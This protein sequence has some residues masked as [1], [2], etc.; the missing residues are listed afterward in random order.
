VK[1]QIELEGSTYDVN[2]EVVQELPV[3]VIDD[4]VTT[5]HGEYPTEP[6]T[7]IVNPPKKRKPR[8]RSASNELRSP[9]CGVIVSV[10][11]QPGDVVEADDVVVVL[12]AMKMETN[13]RAPRTCRVKSVSVQAGEAVLTDQLLVEFE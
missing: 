13:L 12:E 3:P 5:S 8:L 11:V 4:V 1:L 6:A 9:M 2:V 7:R 10:N